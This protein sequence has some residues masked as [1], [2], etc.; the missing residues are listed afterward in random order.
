MP[1]KTNIETA[2]EAIS[3]KMAEM[4]SRLL[5]SDQVKRILDKENEA[6]AKAKDED[7]VTK[8]AE[9][10]IRAKAVRDPA[11]VV[12]ADEA[13]RKGR[14]YTFL[15]ARREFNK[16]R[17][18]PTPVWDDETMDRFG[19]YMIAVKEND[20]PRI[21]KLVAEK[22]NAP[23]TATT[24]AGGYLIPDEFRSELVR[25]A[26][27][28]SLALQL[29]RI[30]PMMSD[31]LYLPTV[32]AGITAVWGTIN[33]ATGDTKATLGQVSLAAN[34]L[35]AVSYV[36]NEL[37]QD[38]FLGVGGFIADEFTSAFA[39][40]IDHE[41]W[42]GDASDAADVFEGWGRAATTNRESSG[43]SGDSANGSIQTDHILNVI[44]KL[45][46]TALVGAVWIMPPTVWARVRSLADS[47]SNLLVNIDK[48]YRYNLFGFPV[49][50]SS[51]MTTKASVAAGDELMLFGN[52]RNYIIGTRQDISVQASPHIAFT[53]DQTVYMAIQRL[54]MAIGIETELAVL[55]KP[56]AGGTSGPAA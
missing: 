14:S 29:C 16:G 52:P 28:K 8:R 12:T 20:K 3:K 9:E 34:K 4:E 13:V 1:E 37:I 21:K 5:P 47:N 43:V 11:Q 46:D 35:V 48:D 27:S 22:A 38:A 55:S 17:T 41:A 40:R 24:S 10:L 50:L 54:A 19:E 7:A 15:D 49:Y 53:A 31:Q 45:S 44:G 42:T 30:V 56:A 51:Q 18:S 36:P 6:A 2:L 25:A 39:E 26:Y 23:Y 32:S 33:T